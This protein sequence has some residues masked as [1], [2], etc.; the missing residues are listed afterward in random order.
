MFNPY[1]LFNYLV[2]GF[3]LYLKMKLKIFF[4]FSYHI[5]IEVNGLAYKKNGKSTQKKVN[6]FSLK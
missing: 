5:H 6:S 4:A 3:S 2:N 1:D